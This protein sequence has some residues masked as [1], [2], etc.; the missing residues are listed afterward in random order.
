VALAL[1]A[2]C[3]PVTAVGGWFIRKTIDAGKGGGSPGATLLAFMYTFEDGPDA[4]GVSR[5][6]VDSK[7]DAIQKQRKAYLAEMAADA[8]KSG[9][10]ATFEIGSRPEGAENGDVINGDKATTVGWFSV[11]WTPPES[12]RPS[13]GLPWYGGPSRPWRAE[14][15]RDDGGWRLLSVT[16]PPWCDPGD[17]TGYSRCDRPYPSESITPSPSQSSEDPLGKV[18]DMLPCGPRD[19]FRSMRACPSS[20]PG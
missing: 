9:W 6:I 2:I 18:R 11:R 16:L 3:V 10:T 20:P 15:R 4:L 1:V 7:K 17:L 13:H 8:Q 14:T 5:L 12:L 19:P